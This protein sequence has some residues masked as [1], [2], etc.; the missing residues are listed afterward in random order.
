L[1]FSAAPALKKGGFWGVVN[2]AYTYGGKKGWMECVGVGG[3]PVGWVENGT[4]SF[5]RWGT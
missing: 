3:P 1:L 4:E 5:E 2:E